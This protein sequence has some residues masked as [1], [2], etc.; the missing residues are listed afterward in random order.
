MNI[1]R[2]AGDMT[3]LISILVLLLKIYATKSCSGI[4]LKTQELYTIVF[5][6]RY[7]DLFTEFISV[8]NTI[9]KIV[10]IVSTLAIVWCMRFHRTVKRSYDRE[11]DTFRHWILIAASFVLALLIH[12]K[13]T[14]LEVF[15]SFSIYLE[16]VAILPQLV[17]LQR[18]GNVDNLTG[19]YVFFLGAY[20]SFYILNW[21]YRYFTEPH[22]SRW[23]CKYTSDSMVDEFCLTDDYFSDFSFSPL[24]L[25]SL[26]LSRLL[27]M[28]IF[29]TTTL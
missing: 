2:L 1:F 4:S 7:L 9:M 11:L 18:S 13:F 15:W 16:A 19:Q 23:I 28:Q 6:A 20:R 10:F 26:E 5:L 27:Y 14:F 8:Y 17:L 22:F 29:S 25:A 21:I 12:E 3:H 24:K